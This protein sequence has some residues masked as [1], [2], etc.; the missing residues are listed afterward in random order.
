[1]KQQ[2]SLK[3][4]ISMKEQASW[5]WAHKNASVD[6]EWAHIFRAIANFSPVQQREKLESLLNDSEVNRVLVEKTREYK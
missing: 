3:R 6:E 5:E 1:M 4:I 2:F